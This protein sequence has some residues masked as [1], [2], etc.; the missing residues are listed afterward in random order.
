MPTATT[1]DDLVAR[2]RARAQLPVADGRLSVAELLALAD[3]ALE[4]SVGRE[5]YDAGDGRWSRTVDIPLVAGVSDYRLP[6]R[7]LAGGLDHAWL[8]SPQGELSDAL[9]Y[10]DRSEIGL[11]SGERV[12]AWGPPRLTLI[13]DVARVMPTPSDAG[14]ALRVMYLRRPSRLV[15]VADCA[16]VTAASGPA[17]TVASVPSAWGVSEVVD[18]V[19]GALGGDAIEDD[20][21][22]SVSSPTIAR[23]SGAFSTSGAYAVRIGDYACLAGTSCVV[24]LPSIAVPYLADLVARDVCIAIG[25][26]EGADRAAAL[27]E[28][29]RRELSSVLAERSRTRPRA[30]PRHSPLRGAGMPTRGWRRR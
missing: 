12:S 13:G 24:Q 8:V 18:V 23:T 16:R 25:D 30:I 6:T 3:D 26:P 21:A 17:L 10:V 29:R 20:V 4:L 14:Y 11:W 22:V 28:S 15:P 1:S 9:A 5:V 2:V 7:A 27:A 19:R